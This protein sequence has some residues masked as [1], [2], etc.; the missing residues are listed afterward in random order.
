MINPTSYY[1]WQVISPF[2]FPFLNK[3]AIMATKTL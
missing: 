3:L 1:A 2:F